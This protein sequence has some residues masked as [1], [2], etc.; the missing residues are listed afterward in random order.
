MFSRLYKF[1]ETFNCIY[2]L[3]FGFRG[4]HST[5]HALISITEQ[6][7]EALDNNKFA[8]GIFVDVQKAFDTVNHT[9]LLRKLE[10][11]GVRDISNEWFRSYLLDRQQYVSINGFDS[12]H[13]TVKHG[14]PQGSVL[15]LLLFLIY[16]KNSQ[17]FQF[18]DDTNLLHISNNT[19]NR[20]CRKINVDLKFLNT[21]KS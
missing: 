5:N 8:V 4:K 14:V 13:T 21:Q 1:L 18:A 11:Y 7:R 19:Y 15:G 16:I 20:M 10:Y 17:V 3:Q 6:I 2:K 9:I 12:K